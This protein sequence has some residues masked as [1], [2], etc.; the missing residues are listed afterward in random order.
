MANH[1]LKSEKSDLLSVKKKI[2]RES[3]LVFTTLSAAGSSILESS[4]L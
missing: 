2:L 4:E 3:R 1:E